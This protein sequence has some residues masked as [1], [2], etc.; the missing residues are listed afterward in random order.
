MI[1]PLYINSVQCNIT[2]KRII[3]E[4]KLQISKWTNISLSTKERIAQSNLESYIQMALKEVKQDS[5]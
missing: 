1:F 2:S 5:V 4:L 3:G